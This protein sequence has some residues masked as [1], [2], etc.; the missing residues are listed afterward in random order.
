MSPVRSRTRTHSFAAGGAR[1]C[2]DE[3][4]MAGITLAPSNASPASSTLWRYGQLNGS[5]RAALCLPPAWSRTAFAWAS[6]SRATRSASGSTQPP[7]ELVQR[8]RQPRVPG[9]HRLQRV[10]GHREGLGMKILFTVLC[11]IGAGIAVYF[12]FVRP[13]QSANKLINRDS[14]F[15]S[16]LGHFTGGATWKGSGGL[17][18]RASWPLVCLDVYSNGLVMSPRVKLIRWVVPRIELEW[19]DI[20]YV[21]RRPTGIRIVRKDVPGATVLFQMNGDIIL[22]Q[23]SAFPVEVR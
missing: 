22:H 4:R 1:D 14:L 8:E 19:S 6:R 11:V 20:Q 5:Y 9:A 10:R 21:D 2:A 15:Q 17:S 16:S 23:I 12:V 13:H 7:A 18:G 3:N